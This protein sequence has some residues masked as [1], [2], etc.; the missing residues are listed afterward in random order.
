[1]STLAQVEALVQQFSTE[2]LLK[3]EQFVHKTRLQKNQSRG[4]SALDL[5]PLD[6]GRMLKPLGDREEW[7]EEMLRDRV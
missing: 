1:M 3:L 6:L 7:Y 4:A 2:D 5:P